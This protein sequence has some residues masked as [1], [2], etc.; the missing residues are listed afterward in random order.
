MKLDEKDKKIL[1]LIQKNAKMKAREIARKI[2]SPITTVFAKIKRMEKEGIIKEYSA[3]LDPK[4][5]GLETLAFIFISFS[6][7]EG[8]SQIETVNEIA[9]F[10]EVQEVHIISGEWDILVKVRA[11]NSEEIGKFVVEKLR[12]IRG[13]EKTLTSVVFTSVKET[14]NLPVD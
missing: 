7:S 11:K 12:D 6:K 3:I 8:V 1:K 14:L 9:K 4:L 13:I 10:P 2:N 5:L